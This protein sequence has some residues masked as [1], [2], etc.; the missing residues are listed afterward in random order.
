MIVG[1]KNMSSIKQL[2]YF[3]LFIFNK[4]IESEILAHNMNYIWR[5]SNSSVKK[6][7][8]YCIFILTN[9]L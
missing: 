6:S 7:S 9:K 2:C 4:H 8:Y 3:T 5:Y 1:N